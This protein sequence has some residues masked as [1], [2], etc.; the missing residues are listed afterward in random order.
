PAEFDGDT[1]GNTTVWPLLTTIA[2]P[3]AADWPALPAFG[4]TDQPGGTNPAAVRLNT[5]LKPGRW[6]IDRHTNPGAA[7]WSRCVSWPAG[8]VSGFAGF[9]GCVPSLGGNELLG[10][11]VIVNSEIGPPT[12]SVPVLRTKVFRGLLPPGV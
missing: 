8:R 10:P 4:V 3:A 9:A 7:A 2:E 1:T 11:S 5:T 6:S 12:A